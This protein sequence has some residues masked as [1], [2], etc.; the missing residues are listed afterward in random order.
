[1]TFIRTLRAELLKLRRT[2]AF[3]MVLAA[4]AL[5]VALVFLTFY[6]RSAFYAKGGRPLWESLQR[7]AFM[8]WSVLMLPL[9]VTL[10]SSL[11]AG[12]EHS[13][14]RWRNLLAMP[15]P[16]WAIYWAKLA[17]L[18]AML[19]VSSV[20]LNLGC[21]L[22]GVLLRTLQPRLLF[23]APVP[24]AAAWQSAAITAM[25]ALAIVA[26]QH[27]VSLRFSAFAASAGFG[28]A[29]TIVAAILVNSSTY[30]PW[31]PW[32]LPAQMMSPSAGRVSHA[33]WYS[34]IA[35][36]CASVIGSLEFSRREIRG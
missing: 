17:I 29:A 36:L 32:C 14:Q 13:E 25:A 6:E 26:I 23:P 10:Q 7:T 11:L 15:V 24:W 33:L 35:A 9:Y 3:W 16:R 28:I 31:W 18:C 12:L 30:G 5:V 4:P 19:V 21:I 8:F 20:L 1:M 2:L 27:W 34:G 22:D